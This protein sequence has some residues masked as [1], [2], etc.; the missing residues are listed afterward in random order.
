MHAGEQKEPPQSRQKKALRSR[1]PQRLQ[2]LNEVPMG[3][4]LP[5]GV[6]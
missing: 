4:E 5:V 2:L 1:F 3:A 6:D